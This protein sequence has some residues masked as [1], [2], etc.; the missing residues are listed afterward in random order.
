MSLLDRKRRTDHPV[1]TSSSRSIRNRL[2]LLLVPTCTRKTAALRQRVEERLQFFLLA[3]SLMLGS[4]RGFRRVCLSLPGTL[5][6]LF[7]HLHTS[8]SMPPVR[9]SASWL[10]RSSWLDRGSHTLERIHFSSLR[11]CPEPA[12][13]FL[14]ASP[15]I[16]C[17][18]PMTVTVRLVQQRQEIA[19]MA[20]VSGPRVTK[21]SWR[22]VWRAP[23]H[24]GSLPRSRPLPH[25]GSQA[26][27]LLSLSVRNSPLCRIEVLRRQTRRPAPHGLP[28]KVEEGRRRPSITRNNGMPCAALAIRS[29][30]RS[31]GENR[32]AR[33]GPRNKSCVSRCPDACPRRGRTS[34]DLA[35]E[36]ATSKLCSRPVG[37]ERDSS[38][39]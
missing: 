1:A 9:V 5:R 28:S 32:T 25:P 23:G 18:G 15:P 2:V 13:P 31:P 20:V 6:T 19:E 33:S 22:K 4:R 12:V 14:P 17:M 10:V 30:R 26:A 7:R 21:S 37:R 36:R 35:E 38:R 24:G 39:D 16:D 3:I 8:T 11:S 34:R 27:S 29:R